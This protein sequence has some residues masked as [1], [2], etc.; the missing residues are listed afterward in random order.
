M[1]NITMLDVMKINGSD[2]T[3]GLIEDVIHA[4]PEVRI[5]AARSIAGTSYKTLIRTEIGKGGF[6]DANSGA[7]PCASKYA[8]K[9]VETYIADCAAEIDRAVAEASEDGPAAL[10]ALEQSGNLEG[11]LQALGSQFYYGTNSAFA[12]STAKEAG[13][14]YNGIS[15]VVDAGL[16]LDAGGTTSGSASSVYAVKWGPRNVQWVIG[17]DGMIDEQD[18]YP[19]RL[20]DGNGKAFDGIRAPLLF[21][22]GLQVVNKNSMGQIKNLTEESGK[23]LDDAK[24]YQLLSKFPAGVVPDAIYLT[25]RSLEQ[26]R[27]S[28]TATNTTGEPAPTPTKTGNGI[29]LIPTDNIVDTENVV[30]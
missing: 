21:W 20:T 8:N 25:R 10:I 22:I 23:G 27:I 11:M 29:P 3:T 19:A 13:K 17:R 7:D 28:R 14:G 1:P 6:R 5:G 16:V 2:R 9:L 30:A 26:L 15:E 4:S 24:L 12:S 18:P